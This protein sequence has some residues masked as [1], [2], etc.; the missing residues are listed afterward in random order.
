MHLNHHEW[1]AGHDRAFLIVSDF[2]LYCSLECVG[3]QKTVCRP[4]TACLH[5]IG[6]I[7][8][9]VE[10]TIKGFSETSAMDRADCVFCVYQ[11]VVMGSVLLN[12]VGSAR[13]P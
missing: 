7:A 1:H 8:T 2:K 11:V 13:P 5:L 9:R 12:L 4:A 3:R 6:S 10:A